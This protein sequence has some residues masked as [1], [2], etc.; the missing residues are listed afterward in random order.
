MLKEDGNSGVNGLVKFVQEPGKKMQ[1]YAEVTGLNPGLHGFH[2]HTFGNLSEGCKT[3]GPHFN[4]EG[5]THGGPGKEIRHVGDLGNILAGE[6]G[7]AK[8]KAEDELCALSGA[9]SII[10]RSV[11]CH[12]G[13]DDL[14][15]GVG[16][17]A[18]ESKKTGNAGARVAC[19]V[20]GLSSPFKMNDKS[21]EKS[22]KVSDSSYLS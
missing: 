22:H 10:G 7:L 13:E 2:I 5:K 21:D 15:E 17:K 6:D 18:E 8:H 3:A 16:E 12:E 14:G 9:F 20:I 1:I 11:V 4:P 19:G